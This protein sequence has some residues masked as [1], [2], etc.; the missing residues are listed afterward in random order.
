MI[1]Y[2]PT[3]LCCLL[4]C[5]I[6]TLANGH[7]AVTHPKPRQAI[8]GAISPWNGTVPQ[9]PV[10]FDKPNWC[11]MPAADSKDPRKLTGGNGQ[12]CFW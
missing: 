7:G 6:A 3:A 11:E 12:A 4:L 9:Y 8:D 2:R 1:K 5:A 10:P